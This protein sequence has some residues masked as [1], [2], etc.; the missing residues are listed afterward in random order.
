[1]ERG[2]E[3]GR[4]RERTRESIGIKEA[5]QRRGRKKRKA[6]RTKELTRTKV[7]ILHF[8]FHSSIL[9]ITSWLYNSAFL[10]F[11]IKS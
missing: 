5:Q 1:M 3:G 9:V 8:I 11:A 6:N 2:R 4:E 7:I 10:K